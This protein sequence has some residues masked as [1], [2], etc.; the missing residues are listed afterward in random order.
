MRTSGFHFSFGLVCVQA[1]SQFFDHSP[2][3]KRHQSLA[4]QGSFDFTFNTD[5]ITSN[6]DES[7]AAPSRE[8]G[9]SDPFGL[10]H[11][12]GVHPTVLHK[13]SHCLRP[14]PVLDVI[15]HVSHC[16]SHV[17]HCITYVS[18]CISYDVVSHHRY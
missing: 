18:N 7:K 9:R 3:K 2:P 10:W 6:T 14:H 8:A 12:R 5:E 4:S 16:I 1:Q 11:E 13:S 17:F 15:S